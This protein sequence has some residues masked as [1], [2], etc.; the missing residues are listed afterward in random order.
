[1]TLDKTLEELSSDWMKKYLGSGNSISDQEII[2]ETSFLAGYKAAQ[3]AFFLHCSVLIGKVPKSQSQWISVKESMPFPMAEV[4]ILCTYGGKD[5]ASMSVG[6]HCE[7]EW[8]TYGEQD[9]RTEE[10]SHWMP[11][12][13]HPV[14]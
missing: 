11:L 9:W 13:D 4:V 10:V 6:W 8:R 2:A 12:P 3:K 14:E 7:H 1:M 5:P